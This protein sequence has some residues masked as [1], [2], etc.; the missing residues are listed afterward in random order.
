M[1][2]SGLC[3]PKSWENR[4]L[5]GDISLLDEWSPDYWFDLAG[6]VRD[7][8]KHAVPL[9]PH[10][11]DAHPSDRV[12]AAAS[13]EWLAMMAETLYLLIQS[14]DGGAW[15]DRVRPYFMAMQPDNEAWL[16]GWRTALL[17]APAGL[18]QVLAHAA[19]YMQKSDTP[20]CW[21]LLVENLYRI[22][23]A[24]RQQTEGDVATAISNS[25]NGRS[26]WSLALLAWDRG[27]RET[28]E[29]VLSVPSGCVVSIDHVSP[30]GA[31]ISAMD[32]VLMSADRKDWL[33]ALFR[34]FPSTHCWAA[35]CNVLAH[36][37]HD[38]RCLGDSIPFAS[39]HWQMASDAWPHFQ[40][41]LATAHAAH[42]D[43][44]ARNSLL[45][46]GR[47]PVVLDWLDKNPGLLDGLLIKSPRLRLLKP[48]LPPAIGY[49]GSIESWKT[50]VAHAASWERVLDCH[51]LRS[52]VMDGTQLMLAMSS[53]SIKKSNVG[54][55]NSFEKVLALAPD[56]AWIALRRTTDYSTR[57]ET[58]GLL[59]NSRLL[60]GSSVLTDAWST[61]SP[62]AMALRC[63][64]TDPEIW[65]RPFVTHLATL[66][67]SRRAASLRRGM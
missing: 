48:R 11:D 3:L 55:L 67:A 39:S 28:W 2:V 60:A 18:R 8:Q 1:N 16:D 66:H 56:V 64:D 9:P 26:I 27:D 41:I 12:R 17:A 24:D 52:K 15:W 33:P 47:V 50:S 45:S 29:R 58:M 54:R 34:A 23:T 46:M 32:R 5:R 37:N 21:T 43:V 19:K 4:A 62:E 63:Q 44:S 61:L 65:R 59:L 7:I 51:G 36:R 38:F 40:F 53:S 20:P 13:A 6:C 25:T 57:L 31:W 49:F 10:S 30:A 22:E 35:V 14:K 42:A